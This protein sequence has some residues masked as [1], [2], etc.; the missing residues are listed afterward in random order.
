MVYE[1]RMFKMLGNKRHMVTSVLIDARDGVQALE[2]SCVHLG[3]NRVIEI[4]E[5]EERFERPP[6]VTR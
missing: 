3:R 5:A 6:M 2:R 4:R 1:I